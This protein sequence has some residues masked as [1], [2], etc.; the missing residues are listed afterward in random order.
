MGKKLWLFIACTLLSASMAFAQKTVTGTVIE[1]ATGE[2]VIGATV[3]VDGTSLGQATDVNGRFSIANVPNSATNLLVSYIGM[4]SKTVAIKSGNIQV[5]LDAEIKALDEVFV[6]AFG[7]ATK[8]T[9]TGSAT[10]VGSKDIE[11]SQSTNVLDAINGKAAGVQMSMGSGQPG[12]S[13]PSMMVRGVTSIFA[14]NSPL[15]V[16]DGAPYGGDLNTI[17]SADIE[18]ISVLKDAASTALYGARAANGVIMVTTKKAKVGDMAKIT[19]DAKWGSN[20]RSTRRYKT[21]ND[22]KH[23]YEAYYQS[24]FNKGMADGKGA[25]GAHEYALANLI[26]G[27]Y[28]L[29]YNPY[30]VPDG[31]SLIGSNGKFNPNATLGR[32]IGTDYFLTTDDWYD[33][34]YKTGS[35]QEYNVTATN[36][37]SNSNFFAS[38]NYLKNEGI[39]INSDF[40]RVGARLKAESQLKDWLKVGMNMNYSHFNG[41]S[42]DEDGSSSSSG[43]ILAISNQIAPIYPLYVRDANGNIMKDAY[44]NTIYDYADGNFYGL[45]RPIFT[46]TNAIGDMT[47]N[48]NSYEGNSFGG[49][50]FAEFRFLKDFKFTSENEVDVLESRGTGVTN[51]YYGSYASSNGI[52]SKS[53][54]RS[55]HTNFQQI[56]NWHHLFGLHDVDVTAIHTA[57]DSR[58]YYLTGNKSNMFDPSNNELAGAVVDIS[59]NSYT[60]RYNTEGYLGRVQYNYDERYFGMVSLRRDATSRFH[61]DNRWGN[62][63]SASAAWLINKEKWFTYDWIDLLKLKASYGEIGNDNIGSY[64]Y[65]NQYNIV[66]SAGNVAVTPTGPQGNKDITWETSHN[67]NIGVD[68]DMFKGRLSGTVEYFYRKTTDMLFSFPMPPSTGFSS[69]YANIGDMRNSGIELSLEGQIIKTKDLVWSAHLNI[70]H[71]KNKITNLPEKRR[72]QEI[73]GVGGFS[74]GNLFFG[75]DIEVSTFQMPQYAGPDP[76]TGTSTW[77]MDQKVAAKDAEGNPILD[78]NGNQVYNTEKVTTTEYSK[79]TKY[80][81]GSVHPDVYGGFGTSVE[82]KGFDFSINFSYQLGGKV[83]DSDYASLMGNPYGS[84]RGHAF[85]ADLLDA[86]SSENPRSDIPAF[87]FGDQYSSTTSDRFLTDA[88]YLSLNNINFGYT[89]PASVTRKAGISRLRVYLAADNVFLWS[90]RQGLDPRQTMYGSDIMSVGGATN[91]LYAPI[92]TISGGLSITF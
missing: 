49:I 77:Y 22:P 35:R 18:S 48:E 10:V 47:L 32:M 63:W 50:G 4:K 57:Y 82:W 8:E 30:T 14:G 42:M 88:S 2:P 45:N 29:G 54:S 25:A 39:T 9:F 38:F 12:Q 36:A 62:F 26:N 17:N 68:F 65:T 75:Q 84:V 13:S 59:S 44:G 85:H 33:Q 15:I 11:Q 19:V 70:T 91:A 31:E 69:Y 81:C 71:Y 58:S 37:T 16:L 87:T 92:R 53:H 7:T 28:G 73:S 5:A 64:R 90:K 83:Y 21:I 20:S 40:E 67:F 66:V 41:K 89:L 3:K 52:V 76:V 80:L 51:P 86:W 1:S 56:L 74:S 23:Y 55:V 24:L 61:P 46:N 60:S 72:T 43:N 79:A 34:A 78:D 27:S 6:V